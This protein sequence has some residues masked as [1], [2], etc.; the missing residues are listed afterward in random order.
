MVNI[1]LTAY[2]HRKRAEPALC[3]GPL[4]KNPAASGAQR[5]TQSAAFAGAVG[6]AIAWPGVRRRRSSAPPATHAGGAATGV[7]AVSPPQAERS[8]ET[9][10]PDDPDTMPTSR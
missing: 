9:G 6:R 10:A 5:P 7:A 8:R 4:P 3:A 2:P 1:A